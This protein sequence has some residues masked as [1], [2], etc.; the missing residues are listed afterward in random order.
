VTRKSHCGD[1]S[2]VFTSRPLTAPP[3]TRNR[4]SNTGRP[5]THAAAANA[6]LDGIA[7][8]ADDADEDDP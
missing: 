2:L 8:D 3:P 5:F 7:D 6:R 4:A 1:P